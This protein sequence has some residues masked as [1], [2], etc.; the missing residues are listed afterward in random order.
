MRAAHSA[1]ELGVAAGPG[2]VA[3]AEATG[4]DGSVGEATSVGA[5]LD[6]GVGVGDSLG[7]AMAAAID[8]W[9]G[10]FAR[11]DDPVNGIPIPTTAIAPKIANERATFVL[12]TPPPSYGFRTLPIPNCAI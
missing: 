6:V 11:A 9:L 2:M 4:V 8:S 10:E 1:L 7:E 5:L 12:R 3:L